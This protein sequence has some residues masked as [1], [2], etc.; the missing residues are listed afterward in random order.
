MYKTYLK[1]PPK[2][3]DSFDEFLKWSST[4]LYDF[5]EIDKSLVDASSIYT[6]LSDIK[7]LESWSVD[8]WSF[9]N[10]DLTVMQNDYIN[11][12]E[13]ILNW[14]NDFSSSLL[15][16]NLAY[17]GLAYKQAANSI[18][19]MDKEWS[20]IW[21]VGLNALTK[22][23]QV[24]LDFLKN[25]NIARVFWD[26]DK[27]YYENEIHEAGSFLREQRSKWSEIDFDGVGN[28]FKSKK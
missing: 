12:Y 8:N 28:Y 6:N 17:Q 11:F 5:N 1:N 2:K 24:I 9:S 22:S 14:Y 26:A 23:E 13:G 20:R 15:S 4:L 27:Y 3:I 16:E 19:S 18:Q 10:S 7:K 25:K 21:F